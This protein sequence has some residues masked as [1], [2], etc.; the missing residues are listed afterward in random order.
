MFMLFLLIFFQ[1]QLRMACNITEVCHDSG[2]DA[3]C[4][5]N[6]DWKDDHLSCRRL[7]VAVHA[8]VMPTG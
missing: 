2:K 5:A 6:H 7:F 4:G 8:G 3:F 1:L